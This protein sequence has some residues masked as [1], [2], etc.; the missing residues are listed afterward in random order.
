MKKI[1]ARVL[2]AVAIAATGAAS[3]GCL[4]LIVDEPKAIESLKD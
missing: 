1:I 3:L 2:A 4:W